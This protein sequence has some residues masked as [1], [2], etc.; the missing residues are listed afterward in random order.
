MDA[1]RKTETKDK[2]LAVRFPE[3][4]MVRIERHRALMNEERPGLNVTL[5][6]TVRVLVEQALEFAESAA[7]TRRGQ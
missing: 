1:Q 7:E 6:A 2:Q 5:S 4:L 3:A